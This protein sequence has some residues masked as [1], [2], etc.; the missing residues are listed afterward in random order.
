[1]R[2]LD[3]ARRIHQ[4]AGITEEGAATLLEWILDFF[5]ITLQ[6][7]EPISVSNFGTFTVHTKAARSGRNPRT[8]EAVIISARRVV[9]FRASPHLKTEVNSAQSEQQEAE[10][11]TPKGK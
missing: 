5:K 3:I 1:M 2:K 10:T 6:K 4:E 9:T 11:L 8:G 7:G